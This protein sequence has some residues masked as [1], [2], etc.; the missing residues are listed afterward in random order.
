MLTVKTMSLD[1]KIMSTCSQSNV[2]VHVKE[3]FFVWFAFDKSKP[4]NYDS[5]FI[6]TFEFPFQLFI[7]VSFKLFERIVTFQFI[8]YDKHFLAYYVVIV[9]LVSS[10]V[11]G[12][13][14][15]IFLF[16]V[17][18]KL[19][20]QISNLLSIIFYLLEH[21]LVFF[22]YI[23]WWCKHIIQFTFIKDHI[24]CIYNSLMKN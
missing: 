4:L 22:S 14:V 19:L 2:V 6:K 3:S 12:K 24:R 17:L 9:Y 23:T 18:I 21:Q 13:F 5:H 10:L 15:I 1:A 11:G 20:F 8:F 7:P 16:F